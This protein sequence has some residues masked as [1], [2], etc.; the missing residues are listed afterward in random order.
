MAEDMLQSECMCTNKMHFFNL[1]DGIKHC[2]SIMDVRANSCRFEVTFA[3]KH[4]PG[5]YLSVVS[6]KFGGTGPNGPK[7]T[8]G[9]PKG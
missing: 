2:C 1:D 7:G 3:F 5:W 9:L 4:F 8:G 6:S